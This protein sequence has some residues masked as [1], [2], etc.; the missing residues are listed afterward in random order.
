MLNF[1]NITIIIIIG[2]FQIRNFNNCIKVAKTFMS[3]ENIHH[4]MTQDKSKSELPIKNIIFYAIKD[5]I[6]A[7]TSKQYNNI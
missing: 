1:L 5:S 3:P 2:M 6:S 7:L 4:F